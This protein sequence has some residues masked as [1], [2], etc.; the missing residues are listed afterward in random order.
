M[1]KIIKKRIRWNASVAPDVVNYRV[2]WNAE[3]SPDYES[4]FSEFPATA[5]EA[6]IP[7]DFPSFTVSTEGDYV[8]GISAVDDVGNESDM[9]MSAAIPLD[10]NPPE[11][12]TDIVVENV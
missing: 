4:Q 5:T 12:P 2:Y 1:A 10:F 11:A 8:F 9:A 3:T 7:D 6:F